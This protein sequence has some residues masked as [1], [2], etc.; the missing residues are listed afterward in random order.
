[1]MVYFRKHSL[2]AVVNDCNESTACH[3]LKV[4]R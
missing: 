1:M 3:G 4:I 2:E